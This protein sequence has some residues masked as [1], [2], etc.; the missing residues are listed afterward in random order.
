[1]SESTAD[2]RFTASRGR[3]NAA[4]DLRLRLGAKREL[5][6]RSFLRGAGVSLALPLLQSARPA[7]AKD[8]ESPTPRRMLLISNN[9]GVLPK[10][11]FPQTTGK[12]YELSPYLAPL[13]DFRNDFT[14]FSGLSHPGVAGG[15]ST[16]ATGKFS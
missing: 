2:I 16:E 14:V 3:L 9:L 1:M 6:R 13:A 10:P 7:S 12:D 8:T 4:E 15:H 11:F 5:N